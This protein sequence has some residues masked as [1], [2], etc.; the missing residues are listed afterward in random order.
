M[1]EVLVFDI[2]GNAVPLLGSSNRAL[3]F[4]SSESLARVGKPH[5]V[6]FNGLPCRIF[7]GVRSPL[8]VMTE[9][10]RIYR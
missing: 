2:S 9:Y 1:F 7:R 10:G 6:T 4:C 5:V 3:V 8:S